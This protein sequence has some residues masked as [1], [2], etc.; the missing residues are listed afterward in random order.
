MID[1]SAERIGKNERDIGL[2]ALG[3]HRYE[4][5]VE[6]FPAAL[7][8]GQL[9]EGFQDPWTVLRNVLAVQSQTLTADAKRSVRIHGLESALRAIRIFTQLPV[10]LIKDR[11]YQVRRRRHAPAFIAAGA[12]RA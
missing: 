3:N 7:V 12:R 11:Q 1:I 10:E 2:V 6:L 9:R 8:I 4:H 5:A